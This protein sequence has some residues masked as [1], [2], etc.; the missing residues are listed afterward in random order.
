M[1]KVQPKQ[2]DEKEIN[3]VDVNPNMNDL[4]NITATSLKHK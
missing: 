4:I 3:A 1:K 2:E